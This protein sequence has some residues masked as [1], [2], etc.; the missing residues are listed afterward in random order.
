METPI[1]ELS[2]SCF[3]FVCRRRNQWP[4]LLTFGCVSLLFIFLLGVSLS[5]GRRLVR[6]AAA[7]VRRR[8]LRRR[9]PTTAATTTTTSTWRTATAATTS[10]TIEWPRPHAHPATPPTATSRTT[11]SPPDSAIFLFL[12]LLLLS[13]AFASSS[14]FWWSSTSRVVESFSL[15]AIVVAVFPCARAWVCSPLKLFLT[16]V[17]QRLT[18]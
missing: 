6:A 5:R 4:S 13:F 17:F 7:P 11:D 16:T 9:A 18:L 2:P 10:K 14:F 12:L 8:R 3:A 15:E 1:L